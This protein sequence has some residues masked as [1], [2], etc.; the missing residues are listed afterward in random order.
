MSIEEALKVSLNSLIPSLE[1]NFGKDINLL[2][3]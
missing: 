3:S 1:T 2:D